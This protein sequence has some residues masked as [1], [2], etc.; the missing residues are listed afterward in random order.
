MS[1]EKKEAIHKLKVNV[2]PVDGNEPRYHKFE[3]FLDGVLMKGISQFE[4]QRCPDGPTTLRLLM[5]VDY[6]GKALE[7]IMNGKTT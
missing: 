7:R 3:L 1:K 5:T 4:V 2:Q 6:D